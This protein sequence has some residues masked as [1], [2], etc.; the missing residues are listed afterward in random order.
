MRLFHLLFIIFLIGC[1]EEK[2]NSAVYIMEE[3]PAAYNEADRLGIWYPAS[4]FEPVGL[5]L[6]PGD[7]IEV[8]VKNITG[9][10]QP[11]LLLGTYSRYKSS[12]KPTEYQ[13]TA[14]VNTVSDSTGGL[15]YL[16]YVTEDSPL[17]E[18]EVTFDGGDSVP[19]YKLGETN[20]EEW[21]NMLSA[22]E[23]SDVHLISNT[24]MITISKEVA[25]QYKDEDQDHTLQ[26]IDSVSSIE[27]YI[28]GIDGSSDLHKP[29]VHK[30]LITELADPD[31]GFTLAAEEHRIMV[32]T[33]NCRFF[34]DPQFS[35]SKA[36]GLWHEIGHHRQALNWDWVEVDE[37]TVN[38]YSLAVL[39]AFGG[40]MKWLKEHKVWDILAEYFQ[41]PL[42]ERNFN[43]DKTIK[44]KG[45][46][47]MFRQLWIAYGDEFYIKVHKLAREA[48]PRVESRT[49]TGDLQMAHFMLLA[50]EASGYN[51]KGFF[52]QWGFKLPQKDFDALDA[53][54]LP[55]PTIDLLKLRE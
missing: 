46:L 45:R 5:Y 1:S 37:V 28:S 54:N 24:A 50:S 4:D 7:S 52:R 6:S 40:D 27:D 41:S 21:L 43:K 18:V 51:L 26:V 14:G 10:T 31:P 30:I 49:E 55:Q 36:W 29:N 34:M 32:P 35:S 38:I 16:K 19:V 13:L 17:G 23:Y 11:K 22:M 44:G 53:L 20:H 9:D 3:K 15:L 47:A 39:Y 25:L 12:D 2:N 8:D 48:N 42:E 33:K